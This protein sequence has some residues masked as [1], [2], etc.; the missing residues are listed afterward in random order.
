MTQNTPLIIALNSGSSSIKFAV[1]DARDTTAPLLRGAIDRIGH[2]D[3]TL[4]VSV[5]AGRTEVRAVDA[6]SHADAAVLMLEVLE[7]AWPL[8]LVMGVGHRVVDGGAGRLEPRHI[9]DALVSDLQRLSQFAPAHL[10]TEIEMIELCRQ[11]M[12][13]AVHV[14]CFDSTFHRMMPPVARLLPLPRRLQK[15]GIER[16]G[17]HG[18]SFAFLMREL[19]RVG[20]ADAARGRVILLHLG[21][22][23]SLA[24]VRDGV[25]IDTTMGF[26]P[27]GGIPMGTRAGD[28]DPGLVLYL[29]QT[30]GMSAMQFGEMVNRQ[31]GLLGISETSADVRV[32]LAS[33][34]ED[35]RAA[36]AL[37]MFCYHVTKGIG[38]YAAALG[39]VDTLIFSGGIGQ[40][41]PEI[42]S[43]ICGGLG[44]L[45]IQLDH[46]RNEVSHAIISVADAPVAVRVMRTDEEAMIA[47]TVR[48]VLTG[49]T[50]QQT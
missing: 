36:E 45:G 17:F 1:Y 32:L 40:N 23:S 4:T 33:E 41:A 50:R 29:T 6:A 3:A 37:A 20:G 38:A 25:G 22:G 15:L 7:A 26:T 47:E 34:A 11:Q 16:R 5:G 10:P 12:P 19:E 21:S 46:A 39:G 27:A 44:F 43:R 30:E 48:A 14:A 9:T 42:R 2:L 13:S 49:A 24:A 31:S 8:S 35:E 28:L 18:L